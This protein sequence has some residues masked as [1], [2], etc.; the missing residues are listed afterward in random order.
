M[1]VYNNRSTIAKSVTSLLNQSLTDFRLVISDDGS[2]DGSWELI[3]EL[4]DSDARIE[5]IRQPRNLNYGNFRFLLGRATTPYFMFA[6]ADDWWHP[7]FMSR[8]V[9][10]LETDPKAVLAVSRVN[11]V[12]REGKECPSTG[13]FPLQDDVERNVARFLAAPDDNS[14]M[15]GVL[16]TVAALRAFPPT[17][18]HA[19]D[20]TFSA[21]TLL[22]GTHV[23]IPAVLMWRDLTP[24]PNYA[25][26]VLRD[27]PGRLQRL[28]PLGP[29]TRALW[30]HPQLR[31][32]RRVQRALLRIN[33]LKHMQYMRTFHPRVYSAFGMPGIERLL[34]RPI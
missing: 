6:A 17:D 14:R 4:A 13:T 23:E 32:S 33:L 21:L 8:C 30:R 7:Q 20:W 12:D 3:R 15:Y 19:Y 1:P 26:Y 18:H 2:S 22:E 10:A 16:R 28:F 31:R 5:P 11:F 27:A 24:A 29:M 9:E 25:H 34:R